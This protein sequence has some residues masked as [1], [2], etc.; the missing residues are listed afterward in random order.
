MART[1]ISSTGNTGTV[2]GRSNTAS[3]T[4][5]IVESIEDIVSLITPDETPFWSGIEK[6]DA[7]DIVHYWQE[8]TLDAPVRTGK[9]QG[10]EP[11]TAS[12]ADW[13]A[14]TPAMKLNHCQ[15]FIRTARVSGTGRAVQYYGR[16]DELDHQTMLRGMEIRRD[17]EA[18]CLGNQSHTAGT[19]TGVAAGWP[20]EPTG[21][22][23]VMAGAPYLIAAGTVS[24]TDPNRL[25]GNH[26]VGATG[27]VT[28]TAGSSAGLTVTSGTNRA[29]TE[30]MVL[31]T[32]RAVTDQGGRPNVLLCS[33]YHAT[34]IANFAYIDPTGTSNVTGRQREMDGDTLSHVVE[35]YRSPHG[36]LSVVQ[37]RFVQGY[38][39]GDTANEGLVYLLEMDKWAFARL[40]DIQVERLA[41]SG[42]NEKA[43]VLAEGTLIHRNTRA[44]GIIRDLNTA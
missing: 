19:T 6:V 2:T 30:L 26:N 33:P 31:A 27:D 4:E 29:L 24:G 18:T 7:K 13:Q 8:E 5:G 32:Q 28:G 17:I 35:V 38:V 42:D 23:G 12:G 16:G 41:K 40:R 36:T 9:Q 11:S 20:H 22:A 3:N 14:S 25:S 15:L 44:S 10:W 34:V 37:D 43:L 1:V 21:A 39:A